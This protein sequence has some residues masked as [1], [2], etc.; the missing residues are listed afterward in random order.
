MFDVGFSELL[1]CFIVALVVLG[2]ERLPK[3]ARTI[4]RFTGQARAYMRNLSAE[5]E[6]ETQASELKAQLDEANRLA[7]QEL[8]AL[9]AQT[10]AAAEGLKNSVA[11]ETDK[12][13]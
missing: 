3:V 2:P 12:L 11:N 6:R 7:R 9:E 13:K 5:L 10:R 4:G 8:S 1:L